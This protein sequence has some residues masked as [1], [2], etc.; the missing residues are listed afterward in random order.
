MK[1]IF[2]LRPR[3]SAEKKTFEMVSFKKMKSLK[4]A[5]FSKRFRSGSEAREFA[6]RRRRTAGRAGSLGT[7]APREGRGGAGG[8]RR[9]TAL[10][11]ARPPG[12]RPPMG[13]RQRASFA[14]CSEG[15]AQSP[16]DHHGERTLANATRQG[17]QERTRRDF[18][19]Q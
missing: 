8:R 3:E 11:S 4:L 17:E 2:C 13:G 10:T 7:G 16:S 19:S 12:A 18:P 14:L 9:V 15:A 1:I 6:E 5:R